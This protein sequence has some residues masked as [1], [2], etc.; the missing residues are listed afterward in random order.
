MKIRR[1]TILI[2]VL[3]VAAGILVYDRLTEPPNR[4]ALEER[5]V[6][7]FTRLYHAR[8]IHYR[9]TWLGISTLENPCDMWAIQEIIAATKPEFVIETGTYRGGGA[10]FFAS[11]LSLVGEGGKVITVDIGPYCEDAARRKLFQERVEFI[12]GSSVSSEVIDRIAARIKGSSRVMVTL[13]SDH[14]KDHVLKEL[15]LYSKFVSVGCYLIV[16]DTSHNG[17]PLA[18]DYGPGPMEALEQFLKEDK[19]FEP[20][21]DPEKFLL[22]FHPKGYLKRVR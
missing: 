20:D 8:N 6:S 14:H 9:T 21:R 18:T 4:P 17:H 11:I 13:D 16:Q 3:V 2:A 12:L 5:L 1:I 19:D 15:R 10:L 7:D 22:T